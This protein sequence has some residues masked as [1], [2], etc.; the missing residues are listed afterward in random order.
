MTRPLYII[1][2]MSGTSADGIDAALCEISGAPP[3]LSVRML[4]AQSTSFPR[5]FQ[6]LIH[7]QGTQ[8]TSRIDALSRLHFE[9]GERFASAVLSL[10]DEAGYTPQQVDLIGL[11]G[12]TVWHEIDSSGKAVAT[13][14][15]GEAAILAERTGITTISNFRARD[16]AAGGQGAPLTSYIDWLLL[17]HPTHWRAVQNIGGISNVTLLPP[18]NMPDALP[19]AFDTGPGN[20]L[21]DEA[22]RALTSGEKSLD[23]DGAMAARGH[24]DEGWLGELMEHPYFQ[25]RGPKSTGRELFGPEMAV[26]LVN[27]GR[28]RGLS[29]EDTLAT[30]TALTAASIADAYQAYAP[31]M[32]REVIIGGGGGHNP[33]LITML[34]SFLPGAE[35]LSHEAV[36]MDTDNKEALVFAVLAYESWYGRPG[37]LAALTGASRAVV[38]GDI[39]PGANYHHLLRETLFTSVSTSPEPG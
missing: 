5:D 30:I 27:E 11:H 35:I 8:A 20:A 14:Q 1:G 25:R 22:M 10:L 6:R 13:L 12:Q 19:I 15:I 7:E 34:K 37:T 31:V 32:P 26:K 2:L 18:L 21:L 3:S 23:L 4:A 38:L 36:G 29:D 28:A 33:T 16:I 17:R 39:T 24:F 9:L